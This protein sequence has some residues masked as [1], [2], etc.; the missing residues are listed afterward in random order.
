MHRKRFDG[1]TQARTISVNEIFENIESKKDPYKCFGYEWKECQDSP[2][3]ILDE[4]NCP[5]IEEL[6]PIDSKPA[7][8]EIDNSLLDRFNEL[9]EDELEEAFNTFRPVQSLNP[10]MTKLRIC[11]IEKVGL[12]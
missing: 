7:R 8:I 9:S 2:L 6:V 3:D 10:Y 1:F 4:S 11:S 12:V 5:T